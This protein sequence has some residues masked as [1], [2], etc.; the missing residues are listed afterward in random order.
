MLVK[1]DNS[2]KLSDQQLDHSPLTIEEELL[3]LDIPVHSSRVPGKVQEESTQNISRKIAKT[4]VATTDSLIDEAK[5][6]LN[7][8]NLD[9]QASSEGFLS[10]EASVANGLSASKSS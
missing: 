3:V 2:K 1:S 4:L 8:N 5:K 6:T 9:F 10:N 7:D